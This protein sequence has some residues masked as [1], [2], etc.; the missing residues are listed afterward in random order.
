MRR[1]ALER[2]ERIIKTACEVYRT[3]P[4]ATVPLD[5]IAKSAGVGIA[6]LYRNFPDR[7]SLIEAC[8]KDMFQIVLDD[9]KTT[10]AELK[11]AA[12]SAAAEEIWNRHINSLLEL[13]LGT[14]IPAFAPEDLS[15]LTEDLAQLRDLTAERTAE[16]LAALRPHG[17]IA[18]EIQPLTF[19]IGLITVSRPPVPGLQKL[20]PGA[21]RE[22]VDIFLAGCA[23]GSSTLKERITKQ[24]TS[25]SLG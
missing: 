21:T 23:H 20:D 17:L 9:Q 7:D 18:A 22:L 15:E 16:I 5:E 8:A 19:I 25:E 10:L 11:E 3:Y 1:D 24:S 12:D 14:L 4:H 6:T 13:G 2:R